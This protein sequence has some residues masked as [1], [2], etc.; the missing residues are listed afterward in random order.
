MQS[1]VDELLAAIDE[2]MSLMKGRGAGR[3]T[4]EVDNLLRVKKVLERLDPDEVEALL[5][6]EDEEE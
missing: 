4:A 1:T 2:A 5:E 3:Y 6:D